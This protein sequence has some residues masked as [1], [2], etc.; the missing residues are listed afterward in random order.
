MDAD[1]AR[2]LRTVQAPPFAGLL[3]GL[4]HRTVFL[5]IDI[6]GMNAKREK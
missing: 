3:Q 2:R 6:T 4:G 1:A 5:H